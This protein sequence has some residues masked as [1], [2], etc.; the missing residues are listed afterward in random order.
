MTIR[1]CAVAL[2]TLLFVHPQSVLGEIY[3]WTNADGSLG[4]TDDPA[5]IPAQYRDQA[6]KKSESESGT[7]GGSV[8]YSRPVDRSASAAAG[9]TRDEAGPG[10]KKEMTEEEKKK[11]EAEIRG[12]WDN[13][14]KALR[15]Y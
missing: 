12:V 1:I 7:V 14:K 10:P 5:K 13:M 4:F 9:E 3:K 2:V 8:N 15:G 11:A 6:V